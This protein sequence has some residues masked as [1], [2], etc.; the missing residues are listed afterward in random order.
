MDT[1]QWEMSLIDVEE[2]IE[3]S[4]VDGEVS[5]FEIMILHRKSDKQSMWM[6][7]TNRYVLTKKRNA[8]DEE[9]TQCT[10]FL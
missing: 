1:S 6:V 9:Q 7:E 10:S 2:Q 5:S 3:E 8:V 4:G